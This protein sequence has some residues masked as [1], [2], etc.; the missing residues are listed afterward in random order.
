MLPKPELYSSEY[1]TW[2]KD[3]QVVA[4]YPTRPP[5]A[6]AA[7][8]FLAQLAVDNPRRVLDVGC[9]PGDIARRL[10]PLVEHVD[11]V[12]FSEGMV[13]TGR[14]LP[15]GNATNLRWLV[16]AVEAAALEPPYTLVTAGESLHW[17][18]WDIV[19]PRFARAL[20]PNGVV[21][22]VGR[23]WEGPTAVRSR[24]QPVLMRHANV[25]V[26]QRVDLVEELSTRRLFSQLGSMQFGAEA[27]LPTLDE[28]IECRHSQRSFSRAHMGRQAAAAFD[29]DTREALA[30]LC[31]DGTVRLEADRLQL[32]VE[33][34]VT[35][36]RPLA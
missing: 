32:S 1:A 30:E 3:P 4:A 17:M 26:W 15:G 12:D 29:A 9:G 11:A 35:W 33:S 21:A 10:A 36:G 27:W 7:I 23:N 20:T 31:A 28:Y 19:L 16:G 22:I 14:L 5:Y 34:S 18:E 13:A 25:R 6:H 8:E 2:F 24:M